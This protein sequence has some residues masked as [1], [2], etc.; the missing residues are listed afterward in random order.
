MVAVPF[1]YDLPFPDV[2]KLKKTAHTMHSKVLDIIEY[3]ETLSNKGK[4]RLF[5]YQLWQ[6]ELDMFIN[7][8]Y[9]M[10]FVLGYL[11]IIVRH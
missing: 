9:T 10:C 2:A 6:L 7:L 11:N 3:K 1:Y 5:Y 4:V 8:K